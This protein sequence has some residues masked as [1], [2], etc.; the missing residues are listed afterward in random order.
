MLRATHG[1][2]N[3][4]SRTYERRDGG[5]G[6]FE[7]LYNSDR[8]PQARCSLCSA[9]ISAYPMCHEEKTSA[10]RV[11]WVCFKCAKWQVTAEDQASG[12]SPHCPRCMQR[13]AAM[14]GK[15]TD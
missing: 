10:C 6:D 11:E 15:Y 4:G 8:M 3:G 14:K 9:S 1:A 7:R 13:V 12:G 2:T 5:E